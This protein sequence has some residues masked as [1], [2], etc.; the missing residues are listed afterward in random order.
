MNTISHY[1]WPAWRYCNW[2]GWY[3]QVYR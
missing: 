2:R 3:G 1:H